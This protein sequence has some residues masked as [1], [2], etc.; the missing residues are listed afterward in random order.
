VTD[1]SRPQPG[2]QMIAVGTRPGAG[3]ECAAMVWEVAIATAIARAEDRV[4]MPGR[5]A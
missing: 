1:N 2:K 5:V 3:A 4:P